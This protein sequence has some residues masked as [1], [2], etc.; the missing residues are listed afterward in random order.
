MVLT[1]PDDQK[2]ERPDNDN[3]RFVRHLVRK[4]SPRLVSFV[5][6]LYF[7]NQVIVGYRGY[8]FYLVPVP[9]S[10]TVCTEHKIT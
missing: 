4:G 3:I 2:D 8:R 9:A 10:R 6:P 7:G 5:S 1:I